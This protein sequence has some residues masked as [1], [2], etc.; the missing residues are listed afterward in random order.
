MAIYLC[1]LIFPSLRGAQRRGNLPL[2]SYI[3]VIARSAATW[4][5]TFAILYSRHCEERSAVAIYLC[6]LIFPSL[7]GAQ[8]RGNLN[9]SLR[10]AQRRGNLP[11]ITARPQHSPHI[12]GL[13]KCNPQ[14]QV[15]SPHTHSQITI[16]MILKLGKVNFCDVPY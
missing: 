11:L 7:R 5:S 10:G 9:P 4:Q 6:N 1:S 12:H 15:L 13:Q 16:Q 3:P 14:Y 8:Q 2:Q